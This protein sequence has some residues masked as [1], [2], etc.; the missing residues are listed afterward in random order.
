MHN[1]L[2]NKVI[3]VRVAITSAGAKTNKDQFGDL[4]PKGVQDVSGL[5]DSAYYNV[6]FGQLNVLKGGNWY[7]ITSYSGSLKGTLDANK[8]LADKLTLK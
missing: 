3:L 5:G 8:L 4:R 7:I 6:E 1:I 2:I